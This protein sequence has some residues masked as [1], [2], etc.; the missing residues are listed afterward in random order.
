MRG[1]LLQA[2]VS[3]GILPLTV[4]VPDSQEGMTAYQRGFA[5]APGSLNPYN[6]GCRRAD[7]NEGFVA[8]RSGMLYPD[9]FHK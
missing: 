5:A 1:S 7:W 9:S 8:R 2:G 3:P 6:I 4:A